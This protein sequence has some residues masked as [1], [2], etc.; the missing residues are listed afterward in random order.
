MGEDQLHVINT[1]ELFEKLN[2]KRQA[3][4]QDA[5]EHH[6]IASKL[7]ILFALNSNNY[8]NFKQEFVQLTDAQL[9]TLELIFSE[10]FNAHISAEIHL[11][12][13]TPLQMQAEMA[14]NLPNQK[15]AKSFLAR[16]KNL[17]SNKPNPV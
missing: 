3:E 17:F 16:L 6:L 5:V 13:M 4:Q 10:H 8:I 11:M 9:K 7:G 15:P 2:R 1:K 12:L 14:A